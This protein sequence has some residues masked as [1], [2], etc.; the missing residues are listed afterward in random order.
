MVW[1]HLLRIAGP[2]LALAAC[3]PAT[4]AGATVSLRLAGSPSDARVTVD[5]Q[6]VGPLAFVAS[7]GVALPPGK[8]RVTIEAPGYFPWDRLVEARPG[9]GPIRL[10]VGLVPVPE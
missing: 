7:R 10:E 9:A 6:L 4:P 3:A 2:A 8:H 5:D 1:P